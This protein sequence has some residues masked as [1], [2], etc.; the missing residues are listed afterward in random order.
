MKPNPYRYP[1]EKLARR[2]GPAGYS[3]YR[4]FVPWLRDEFDFRCTYCLL[5]E[6]WGQLTGNFEV[7]HFLPKSINEDLSLTYENLIHSCA[8]CNRRKGTRVIP[9]P[10][11]IAY[12]ECV[13]IDLE[14][15]EISAKNDL[16][17]ILID[18]LAL[19][20]PRK[21]EQRLFFISAM[22]A[23]STA[24]PDKLKKYMGLPEESSLPDLNSL[25]K[26]PPYN[27][28]PEG[29]ESSWLAR[30]KSGKDIPNYME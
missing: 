19:D 14:T 8:N 28:K 9:D 23:F 12:G 5:R 4:D 13:E 17:T 16:G 7:D 15:G 2:H 27:S 6:V 18:E 26:A 1:S 24:A 10:A 22:R 20:M 21:T 29:I 3:N 11:E 25:P 30:V